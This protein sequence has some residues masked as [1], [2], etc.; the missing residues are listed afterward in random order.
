MYVAVFFFLK[1]TQTLGVKVIQEGLSECLPL[2]LIGTVPHLARLNSEPSCVV[3]IPPVCPAPA[4]NAQLCCFS[5]LSFLVL[6]PTY[7]RCQDHPLLLAGCPG[8]LS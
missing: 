7:R 1:M 4:W 8:T 2:M 3:V 5:A 6:P